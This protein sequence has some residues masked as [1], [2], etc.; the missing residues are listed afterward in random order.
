[1]DI[2]T[3]PLNDV[4]PYIDWNETFGWIASFIILFAIFYLVPKTKLIRGTINIAQKVCV[5]TFVAS[6]TSGTLSF[7]F[8]LSPTTTVIS[9]A[10]MTSSIV[11]YFLLRD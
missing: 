9:F 1:M 3:K 11:G 6:F 8:G 7:V 10:A 5:L 2:L 4:L